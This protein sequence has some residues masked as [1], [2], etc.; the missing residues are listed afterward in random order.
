LVNQPKISTQI[1]GN[2]R[3]IFSV[4][5]ILFFGLVAITIFR[6]FL[7]QKPGLIINRKGI[8][9]N[10]SGLSAGTILWKDIQEIT[11]LQVRNQKFLIVIVLNPQEY[12]DKM[13]NSIKRNVMKINYKSYGSPISIS[14]NPLQTDFDKL[15]KLISEKMSY[16]KSY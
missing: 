8:I 1:L 16:Y 5:S 4:A 14:A 6:K 9:D 7:D 15:Y 12:I 11:I 2:Q 13:S 3:T 10:S